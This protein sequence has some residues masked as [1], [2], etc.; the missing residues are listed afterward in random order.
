MGSPHGS[1]IDFNR[2]VSCGWLYLMFLGKEILFHLLQKEIGGS[3][4]WITFLKFQS[5]GWHP[6]SSVIKKII[7]SILCVFEW[8][9]QHLGSWNNLPIEHDISFYDYCI[10]AIRP[11]QQLLF[12]TLI[13]PWIA[14]Y[15]QN[16]QARWHESPSTFDNVIWICTKATQLHPNLT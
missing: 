10:L 13:S 14:W 3:E 2:E 1:L 8:N 16:C 9:P 6:K 4:E 15:L 7:P 12:P 11:H 5:P